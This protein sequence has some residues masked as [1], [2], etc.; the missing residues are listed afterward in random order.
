MAPLLPGVFG[1]GDVR[2]DLPRSLM[3]LFRGGLLPLGNGCEFVGVEL[4]APRLCLLLL[5][6]EACPLG[7]Q[8]ALLGVL[9]VSVGFD[10]TLLEAPAPA[11]H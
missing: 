7:A 5:G 4:L 6:G 3:R 11:R 9:A 1:L 8:A 2:I 10:P